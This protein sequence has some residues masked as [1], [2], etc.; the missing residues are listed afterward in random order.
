VDDYLE[1]GKSVSVMFF[2]SSSSD[3]NYNLCRWF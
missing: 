3:R 1:G 2:L